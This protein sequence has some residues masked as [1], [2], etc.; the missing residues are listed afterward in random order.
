MKR[1]NSEAD[2]NRAG[3]NG[4]LRQKVRVIDG[5]KAIGNRKNT[6]GMLQYVEKNMN[7]ERR[8]LL[9]D[10]GIDTINKRPSE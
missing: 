1:A 2:G 6:Q 10:D 7:E 9:A 8:K 5:L 4:E 3:I